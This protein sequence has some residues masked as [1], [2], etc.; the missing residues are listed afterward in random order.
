MG[1]DTDLKCKRQVLSE[2][3][4]VYVGLVEYARTFTLAMEVRLST[5]PHWRRVRPMR[6]MDNSRT[7]IQEGCLGVFDLEEGTY[8]SIGTVP[9]FKA[10]LAWARTEPAAGSARPLHKGRAG[11]VFDVN[12]VMSQFRFDEPDDLY[13]VLAPYVDSD[14]SHI[15]WGTGVGTYS[16]LYFSDALGWH[17]QE[18]KEF[19][20]E[21]RAR[22]ARVMRMLAEHGKDPLQMAVEFGR[23]H[24]LEIWA[25][26]RIGKNHERDFC[27]DFPGGG[28][29]PEHKDKRVRVID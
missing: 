9:G 29:L 19:M 14:L 13:N 18:Q 25:N 4:C 17:G 26:D 15:F 28:F 8:L 12:M 5:Q 7:V 21:H 2:Q 10:S 22:T 1:K 3:Y 20:A 27:D 16:P 6:F 23:K 24:G 11:V